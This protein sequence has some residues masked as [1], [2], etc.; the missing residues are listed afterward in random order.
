[1]DLH[2]APQFPHMPLMCDIK[3]GYFG[4][5]EYPSYPLIFLYKEERGLPNPSS[6]LTYTCHLMLSGFSLPP[7][8]IVS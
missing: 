5:F 1:M 4:I 8:E 7:S 2:M 6:I 3:W